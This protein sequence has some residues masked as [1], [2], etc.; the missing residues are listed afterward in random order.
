MTV[1]LY[2]GQTGRGPDID[3]TVRTAIGLIR[4]HMPYPTPV[5]ESSPRD[6]VQTSSS[7]WHIACLFNGS[8][9]VT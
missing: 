6:I 3:S 5:R 2:R 4:D 7:V 1:V 9:M 8:A